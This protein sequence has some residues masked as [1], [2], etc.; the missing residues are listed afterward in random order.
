MGLGGP[1][2]SGRQWMPWVHVED[3]VGLLVHATRDDRIGGPVNAV[4]PRPVT[5]SEL[6]RALGLALHRPALLPVPRMM[7]RAAFGEM[8]DVLTASQRVFPRVAERCG[9]VFK[10]AEL[11]GALE[12]VLAATAQAPVA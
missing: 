1:L 3:L 7:P 5:N 4:G 12:A 2:G 11:G 9:Y 6:T 10:H 8:S